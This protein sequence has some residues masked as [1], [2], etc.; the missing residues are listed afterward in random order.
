MYLK[1]Q[2]E[3]ITKLDPKYQSTKGEGQYEP[4]PAVAYTMYPTQVMLVITVIG[5]MVA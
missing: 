2:A 4:D 3:M 5:K 1:K